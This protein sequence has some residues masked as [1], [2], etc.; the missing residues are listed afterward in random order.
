MKWNTDLYDD[1]QQFVS[2]YGKDLI[3]FIPNKEDQ[4]ILDLGCGTGDLTNQINESFNSSIIGVDYSQEMI[5]KAKSKYPNL[6]FSI[7][8]ACTIPFTNE[9][10]VIFSNAVFH[11]IPNQEELHR[12]IYSALKSGGILICEFGGYKNIEKISSA[13][14]K[15]IKQYGD[16]YDSPFYF[17]KIEEHT[18]VVENCGFEIE[19]IYDY[20]R[21]TILPNGNLGLR[22][23]IS[24][25]FSSYLNKYDETIQEEILVAVENDLKVDMF[26]D[27]NWI[28][29][30]RRIRVIAHKPII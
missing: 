23:W 4:R 30:Y 7:C 22:Q 21:P 28:A 15:A 19:K 27:N 12:S 29:D 6:E 2:E 20:D 26:K 17:P 25:F 10:D 18:K 24:Q 14:G 3:S 8:D 11:W 9:F 13:F 1:A 16:N 5:Q